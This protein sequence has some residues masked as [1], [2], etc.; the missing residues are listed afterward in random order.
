[1]KF[2]VER[3]LPNEKALN[4]AQYPL[5]FQKFLRIRFFEIEV[6]FFGTAI[7]NPFFIGIVECQRHL[8]SIV[9]K[10]QLFFTFSY[11]GDKLIKSLNPH[12]LLIS[13]LIG[14]GPTK[15][16]LNLKMY[17]RPVLNL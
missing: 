7:K 4:A 10:N 16:T 13:N 3:D 17:K 15:S 8:L 1:M 12:T 11:M 14:R 9:Q 5:F 2:L 6:R